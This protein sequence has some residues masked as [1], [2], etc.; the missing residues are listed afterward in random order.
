MLLE[1]K[2]IASGQAELYLERL[3]QY[4]ELAAL[5]GADT[6]D[7]NE[8]GT[9]EHRKRAKEMLGTA[10]SNLQLTLLGP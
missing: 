1:Q 7:T 9:W 4:E 10:A 2:E 8:G 3:A 6:G 5:D